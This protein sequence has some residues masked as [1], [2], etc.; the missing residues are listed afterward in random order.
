MIELKNISF[1]Y[2]RQTVLNNISISFEKGESCAVIGK[3][4]CG[5]TTLAKLISRQLRSQS[6]ELLLDGRSYREYS[7]KEFAK[8]ISYFPQ[9][10]PVP[11]MS[12]CDY[13]AYGRY[14]Y[15]DLA[16]R[17]TKKDKE[18]IALAFELTGTKDFEKKSLAGLSGGERQLVYLAMLIAQDTPYTVLDEPT[19]FMD[20]SNSFL[21][22]DVAEK[23]KKSG[24]CVIAVMHDI[25]QALKFFDRVAVV[26]GGNLVADGA[27]EAILASGVIEST[28]GVFCERVGENDYILKK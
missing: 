18:A 12:V 22:T 24:K 4:G 5:K 20:I 28:F 21:V 3:N 1:S 16:F 11:D 17:L 23:M 25:P 9:S 15:S 14:P 13:V 8:K 6:G 27:P 2:G 26:H 10:R 7:E 19:A